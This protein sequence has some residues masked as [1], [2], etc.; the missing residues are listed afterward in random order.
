MSTRQPDRYELD[1]LDQITGRQG[2]LAHVR[3]LSGREYGGRIFSRVLTADRV[4][5]AVVVEM[6]DHHI[7]IR[8]AAVESLATIPEPQEPPS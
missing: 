8:W 2:S 6:P 4:L 1:A 5:D 7:T 3:T